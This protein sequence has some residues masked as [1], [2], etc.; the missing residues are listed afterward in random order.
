MLM[1][2]DLLHQEKSFVQLELSLSH[3]VLGA[4]WNCSVHWEV[5]SGKASPPLSLLHSG[6]ITHS[7]LFYSLQLRHSLN[8]EKYVKYYSKNNAQLEN[9]FFEDIY[10]IVSS[11]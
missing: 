9:I 2:F 5:L 8:W 6:S 11:L 10:G 3:Q 1:A 4:Q 7:V